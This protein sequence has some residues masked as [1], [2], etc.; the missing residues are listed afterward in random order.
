MRPTR[1]EILGS[2]AWLTASAA[3]AAATPEASA[4]GAPRLA[5][6]LLATS[7]LHMAVMDWDYYRARPDASMGLARVST[8]IGKARKER[9]NTL[10][11]DN[12]DLLQGKSGKHPVQSTSDMGSQIAAR[13]R[14]I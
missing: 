8:L 5:L 11:F 12:G 10:L 4:P 9:P 14:E 7:D 13:I 6:R 1:R 3:A 2:V